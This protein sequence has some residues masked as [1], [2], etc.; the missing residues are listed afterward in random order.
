[1]AVKLTPEEEGLA[2]EGWNIKPDVISA[3]CSD[4][5]EALFEAIVN[6]ADVRVAGFDSNLSA[7]FT[8]GT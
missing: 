7:W 4:F 3:I 6:L 5:S 1:M 2:G 8:L